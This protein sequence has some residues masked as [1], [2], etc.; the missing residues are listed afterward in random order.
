M[1]A[2]DRASTIISVARDAGV[3]IATV[4]RV[5]N[6]P[7]LVALP[8]RHRVM[9]VIQERNFRV[10]KEAQLTRRRHRALRTGRIGFLVPNVPHR[11]SGSITEEMSKGIQKALQARGLEMVVDY[12]Q[13]EGNPLDAMPKMLR[14]NSVDGVLIR[15]PP[16]REMLVEFCRGRKA[17]VLGNTF[18]DLD[19]PC[20]LADDWAGMRMAMDYLF[21]LG[22][23]RIGFVSN[24][25]TSALNARRLQTYR[26]SIEER[27]LSGDDRLVKVHDA[28]ALQ[29]D[30]AQVICGRFLDE[31][32]G[33][34]QPPTAIAATS[35][36]IA[37]ALL[38]AA[39]E[40]GLRVPNHLSLTGFGDQFYAPFT[41]P[42]LTTV[43]VDQRATGEVGA[44]QLL[45]LIEGATYSSQTLVR[46]NFVERRSCA[47]VESR[48]G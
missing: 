10:S 30:E 35:D 44:T 31:L 9:R 41:D 16:H 33:L 21:E 8:T 4:S 46:P 23:R 20:V 25:L 19:V 5:I 6:H 37:V 27:G 15:P 28:W 34:D 14:E 22:H 18:A 7:D 1:R 29:A 17:V 32:L 48:E 36:G 43:H 2:S 11:S 3:S 40:R 12:F 24:T 47:A 42:P 26:A 39:R 45:Q 38:L 13:Y